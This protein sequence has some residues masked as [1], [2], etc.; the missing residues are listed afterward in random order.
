MSGKNFP[1]I[2]SIPL[3]A[4]NSLYSFTG[5]DTPLVPPAIIPSEPVT[6]ASYITYTVAGYTVVYPST[7]WLLPN[8]ITTPPRV[9]IF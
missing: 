9:R 6:V 1:S 7:T 3:G 5:T 8:S 2:V 4:S